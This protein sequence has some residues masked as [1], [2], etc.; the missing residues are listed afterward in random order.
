[1]GGNG[2]SGRGGGC[3][4]AGRLGTGR[5]GEARY[6]RLCG[7]P[8]RGFLFVAE[9]R[10]LS[11]GRGGGE[12][13]FDELILRFVVAEGELV[14]WGEDEVVDEGLAAGVGD[15]DAEVGLL[16]ELDVGVFGAVG[17]GEIEGFQ[18]GE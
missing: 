18:R 5:C 6:G 13:G 1:M 11:G 2:W 7:F 15:E 10:F 8:R 14:R 3:S 12:L 9:D 4:E 16:L 17:E